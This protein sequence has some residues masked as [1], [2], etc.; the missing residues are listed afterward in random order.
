MT[1]VFNA[2]PLIVLAKANLLERIIDL[3]DRVLIPREV[4][5]EVKNCDDP[6]DPACQWLKRP[7][8]VVYLQEAPHISDFVAAWGLGAGESSV[9]SLAGSLPDATAVLD[10]LAARRCAMALGLRVTGTLGLLLMAKKHGCIA[11]VSPALDAIVAAG[12]FISE[13]HL[14][15]IRKKASEL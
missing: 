15:A 6:N 5:E 11:K 3:P 1:L 10:D 4:A 9:L 2:S 12:L 14:Q 8:A 7:E 13:R